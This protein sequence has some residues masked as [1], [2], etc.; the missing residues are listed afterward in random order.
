MSTEKRIKLTFNA[1]GLSTTQ[2]EL[3]P[4]LFMDGTITEQLVA[5]E[6]D[7]QAEFSKMLNEAIEEVNREHTRL[8]GLMGQALRMPVKQLQ[9][10]NN[11]L[12]ISKAVVQGLSQ[13]GRTPNQMQIAAATGLSRKTVQDHLAQGHDNPVF[14]EH[15]RQYAMMAPRV[16]D[17]VLQ[18]AI[19]ENDTKA[20][21]LYFEILEKMKGPNAPNIYNIQNN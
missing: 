21:R 9:W 12:K 17:A 6:E 11:H 7:E 5:L 14:A 15:L 4:L 20:A 8:M 1:A 10:E 18:E 3:V 16:M 13:N 19:L 2:K